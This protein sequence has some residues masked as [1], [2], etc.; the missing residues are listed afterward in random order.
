MF[1]G[2]VQ[3][4]GN[5]KTVKS[6]GEDVQL[7]IETTGLDLN[8]VTIGDSIAVNGVCLTVTEIKANLWLAHV[9]KATLNVTVG[10]DTAK[11]VNCEKALRLSDRLGGHLL[12]GHVDGVGEVVQYEQ[13]GDCWLLRVKVPHA[14]SQFIAQKGSIAVDGVSLTVNAID[15]DTFSVNL[16]PHTVANT[17]L[18]FL[19]AGSLVN[20]EVDQI[21]R[22]V[23]RLQQWK[24]EN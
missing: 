2:I 5:I 17:T 16:I 19:T 14:I 3:T 9:S 18:Q 21:A 22:Y 12:S 10:L 4:I 24:I 20:C 6:L 8:D 23:A 15:K 11:P 7:T 1:T 13:I